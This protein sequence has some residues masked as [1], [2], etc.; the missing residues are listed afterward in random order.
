MTLVT[1]SRRLHPLCCI[2]GQKVPCATMTGC[3][4]CSMDRDHPFMQ[5]HMRS[6]K[7]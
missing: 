2:H 4:M 6:S 7:H 1:H 3:S 5:M